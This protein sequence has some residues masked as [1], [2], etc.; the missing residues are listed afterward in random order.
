MLNNKKIKDMKTYKLHYLDKFGNLLKIEQIE[1]KTWRDAWQ[2]AKIKQAN[3]M[4]NDL[5]IIKIK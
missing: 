3:S 5:Q 1:S 2:I 4:I